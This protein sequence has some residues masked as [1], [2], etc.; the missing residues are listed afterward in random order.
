MPPAASVPL[1]LVFYA[2]F[3]LVL[4]A[5]RA[6]AF[7][8]GFLAGYLAYDMIHY[9]LHHHTP[10]TRVGKLA[11]GAAHAPSLPGR[12]ARL[13]DQRAVLGSRVRHHARPPGPVGSVVRGLMKQKRSQEAE[14]VDGLPVVTERRRARRARRSRQRPRRPGRRAGRDRLRR[15][16]PRRSPSSRATAPRRRQEA[17]EQPDRRDHVVEL[18][19]DR[20]P[21]A[22]PRL[23]V[24]SSARSY[25]RAGRSGS[26]PPSLDGSVTPPRRRVRAAAARRR[27]AGRGRRLRHRLRRARALD[28]AAAR[29]GI[30]RMRFAAGIDDDLPAFHERFRDDPVIG[31]AVRAAPWLRVR[32][33]PDPW[34]TL[35]W[36]I[37]EQ[38][39]DMPRALAIQRRMIAALGRR[40]GRPARLAVGGRRSRRCAPAE[41]EACGLRAQA[42]AGDAA[43]R[44]RGRARA[45]DVRACATEPDFARLLAIP[46]DRDVDGRDARPARARAPRRRARRR[47]RLSQA[48]RAP[49]ARATRRRSPT[50]PRCAGSSR[51]T[52]R[53]PASPAQYLIRART[54]PSPS[55]GRNSLVSGGASEGGS[56][57]QL[58]RAHPALVVGPVDRLLPAPGLVG[59]GREEDGQRRLDRRLLQAAVEALVGLQQRVDADRR[60]VAHAAGG[61]PPWR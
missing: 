14:V 61:R 44:A 17:Q 30:A 36:S 27:R 12:R 54:A 5:D 59:V 58:V 2:A 49:D 42:R 50:R 56:L 35:M 25:G 16:A 3:W 1:A 52:R 6:F 9:H 37:T 47:P 4:G 24:S 32:R 46:R 11:A 40:C 29:E 23:S 26:G 18:V 22:A 10:R 21:P 39:I 57:E 13:R 51:P 31:R 20:R 45:R 33:N 8:A 34:E 41:L 43:C 19:P 15:A 7:G 55:P 60:V 28:E 53:G 48:R 38:L